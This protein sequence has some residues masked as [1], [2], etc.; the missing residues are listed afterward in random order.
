MSEKHYKIE[1]KGDFE[2]LLGSGSECEYVFGDFGHEISP[3]HAMLKRS[4]DR[5]FLKDLGSSR[6]TIINGKKI[7]VSWHEITL[8]DQVFLGQVPLEISPTLLLGRD[9]VGLEA[10]D[11]YYTIPPKRVLSNHISVSAEPGTL[12]AIM[13]P[14]GAGKTV[15]LNLM[16]GYLRPESGRVMVGN[17]NVHESFGL[18]K[19]IVGY[20]PQEDTLIPELTVHQSLHYCLR[21]GY[22]D[23]EEHTRQTLIENVLERMG[24]SQDRLPK[25]LNT[26][27]GS[28]EQRGLSGGERRR[29]NIA[30]EL[31]R[32]PLLLYL[33]EPTSGLSSVDSEHV[34]K[35]LKDICTD[36]QVTM[37]MTIHQPSKDIFNKLDN[38]LLMN[39][40]GNVAYFGPACDAVAY[41]EELTQKKCGDTNPA[42]YIL[43]I[44]DEWDAPNPPETYFLEKQQKS[45]KDISS[46]SPVTLKKPLKLQRKYSY[47]IYQFF[48]LLQRNLVI[49]FSDKLSTSLLI[50]QAIII[51]ILLILTFEGFSKDF[52]DADKFAKSWYRFVP[53]YYEKGH[54]LNLKELKQESMTW[55]DNNHSLIGESSAQRRVSILFLLIASALWFGIVNGSRE[56]VS[57]KTTLKREAKGHLC[58]SSYLTAKICMLCIIAIFQTLILLCLTAFMLGISALGFM[59]FWLVLIL[60]STAASSLSLLISASVRTEQASLM[61]VPIMIIPQ[62]FLGGLIRPIR[63]LADAAAEKLHFT[64][65]ILQKWAFKA[66]LSFDSGQN[67]NVL[68]QHINFKEN[69]IL[70]ALSFAPETMT[71][72]FFGYSAPVFSVHTDAVLIILLHAFIPLCLTYLVLK[73]K[74]S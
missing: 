48:L 39:I 10:Y 49:R 20:V 13:G 37:L 46:D 65:I 70:K 69:H 30:H 15:L 55:A 33:D 28:A 42:D 40:G 2:I 32:N 16:S 4:G 11:L 17:F 60:T 6:G 38:L 31:V 45:D 19:D 25:L 68:V 22:P 58:V 9:R 74:H 23:M 64:D 56:I 59:Q 66:I 54:A 8:H 3:K 63:F 34:V 47:I 71:D 7:G 1:K 53:Q 5:L 67:A 36:S 72:V 57:E 44:L 21:L 27:I 14:S 43:K 35:L 62:L 50:L 41:F 18:V 12:T 29:V 24:F 52:A 73:K 26:K 61:A 51:S